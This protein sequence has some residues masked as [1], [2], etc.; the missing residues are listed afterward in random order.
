MK[1]QNIVR[2]VLFSVLC[3]QSVVLA[4]EARDITLQNGMKIIVREDSRSPVAVHMIWYRAGSMDEASGATGVAHALEHMMFKGTKKYGLGEF[5]KLVARLGGRDNAFTGPDYT[6]YFQLIPARQLERMMELEADRM[7]NLLL[8][9]E[10]FEKEIK[11]VMEERRWRTEDQPIALLSE[12]VS[13]SAFMAH[14]YRWP[15]I[16]W[17]N[18]LENMTLKDLKDWYERWYT[19]NNATMVV[20]GDVRA[21]SVF[22]LA[23]K[24]F[25]RIRGREIVATRPQTEPRQQGARRVTVKA[26]AENPMILMVFKAPSLRDIE[27]DADVYALS[28]LAAILDG[29]DNA[30]LA[31]RLVR[32]NSIASDVSAYYDP[33]SRGPSLFVLAATPLSNTS[34]P[35]LEKRLRAEITQVAKEGVSQKEL[36]RIKMQIVSSQIYKRD[37]LRGQA[38]EIGVLEMAGAGYQQMDVLIE[39]LKAVSSDDV[40]AVAG[41][42]FGDDTMTVGILEPLPPGSGQSQPSVRDAD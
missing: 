27:N 29:Y 4:Q 25:G 40:R 15:V 24:H 26:P 6:A 3:A 16:G 38:M 11:V 2:C 23:E 37:S 17:M 34:L 32:E 18:D 39:K 41:R 5:S 12:A 20:V 1:I 10:E 33:L 7:K 21:E 30:R 31:A 14:P 28:V 9:Q 42:Y 8:T 36:E 22:L 19:P 35:E 13:A